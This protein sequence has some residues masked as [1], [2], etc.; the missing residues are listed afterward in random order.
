MKRP[1]IAV[2]LALAVSALTAG[3]AGLPYAVET[4]F[5]GTYFFSPV[6]VVF[7][8]GESNRVFVVE[9]GGRVAVVRDRTHPQREVFIDIGERLGATAEDYGLLA[10]AFH[11]DF[12]TNGQFFLWYSVDLGD[13]YAYR[14]GR[15]T[16]ADPINGTASLDSEEPLITRHTAY[17]SHD[18]GQMFFGNDGYL[19]LSIGDGD[20]AVNPAT[21][22]SNQRV[23]RDFF[24]VVVRL[25]VDRRP[26]N[27]EPNPHPSVHPGA[28]KVPADNPFVG[29]ASF[30]GEA[31][32]HVDVRTEVFAYG[33]RNPFRMTIDRPTGT[34]WVA[35]VGLDDIEEVDHLM[36]GGNYG[37]SYWEGSR[38]GPVPLP[39]ES[40]AELLAPVWEYTHEVGESIT[41][42]IVYRGAKFPELQGAYL[43]AD[44]LTG[45]IWALFDDG[46][47][48]LPYGAAT[49]IANEDF[50]VSFAEDP[51][52]GDILMADLNE[53]P[54]RRLRRSAP[55]IGL[56]NLSA[57]ARVGS[58]DAAVIPGFVIGDAPKRVLIRAVG[59]ALAEP[60]FNIGSALANPVIQLVHQGV[61]LAANSTWGNASDA[62]EIRVVSAAAGAIPLAEGSADAAMLATL[63][64]GPYT[65][66]TRAAGNAETGIALVELYDVDFGV[67]AGRLLNLSVR[68]EVGTGDDVLTPGLVVTGDESLRLLIRAIGPSLAGSDISATLADPA[69]RLFAGDE[70][71][72]ENVGWTNAADPSAIAA[73]AD[74]TG[75]FPLPATSADSA[76]VI[77][78]APGIYTLQATSES[79]GSGIVLVEIYLVPD[80]AP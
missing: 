75:A 11:P 5:G 44:L 65:V 32:D 27:L 69:L 26:E 14:L 39:P 63:A 16:V 34:V 43:C 46:T 12:A 76:L 79:G 67:G 19:Y 21:G 25:D 71:I 40:T 52:T 36:P 18:G 68:A 9:R 7:A 62:A 15:F 30:N 10:L 17:G 23:D 58:G 37:W 53:G 72:A 55:A 80:P 22:A 74:A 8:P 64:P 57:R 35:D 4:A 29:I 78:L 3:A 60:P 13:E 45:R 6:E 1:F 31:I 20:A 77:E 61:E 47:R 41:G 59:P 33:L 54:I 28:Y 50:I 24:G 42:G 70:V 73:A 49:E 2:F 51:L 48:P 56:V 66:V 38:P